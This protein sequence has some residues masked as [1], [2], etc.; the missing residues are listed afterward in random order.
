L[1]RYPVALKQ[2]THYR[3][4]FGRLG[5]KFQ[6]MTFQELQ[7]NPLIRRNLNAMGYRTPR[8][9]QAQAIGP[10]LDGRDVI[11]LAPT[12]TGKTAAFIAPIAHH[13]LESPPAPGN[14]RKAD[15][16]RR[17]R[18]LVLCPTRELAVQV[19]EEA[20][21]IIAGTVLRVAC[22]YGK[23][24]MR[25]QIEQIARGVDLLVAT[26]GRV[27]E[28]LEAGAMNLSHIRHMAVD[29]ADRMLDMGFLPQVEHILE[30][31]PTNRQMALFTATMPGPVEE[32][33]ARFLT[34]PVRI[35]IGRHTTPAE[36]VEQHL[37]EVEQPDKIAMLLHMLRD[38]QLGKGVLIF[39]RTRRRVGWVGTALQRHGVGCGIIHGDRTQAQRLRALEQ[40]SEGRL[41]VIVAS[42]VA[43]RGL[44]I[45]AVTA[46]I[47]YDVPPNAEEYVHRIGRAGHGG[48]R[49]A[50]W[51]LLASND[52]QRWTDIRKQL[53]LRLNA[54]FIDG[55]E[56]TVRPTRSRAKNSK[57]T[58]GRSGEKGQG[59]NRP[60]A[61]GK[62][63]SRSRTHNAPGGGSRKS[64]PIR[65]GEQPGA[66]VRRGPKQDA[67]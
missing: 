42:D 62:S 65:K 53:G 25:D 24:G 11:G 17:L 35:E 18:G 45:P 46:V 39:C 55:F 22:A 19:A 58:S 52:K 4:L 57:P 21:H 20:S 16:A 61:R 28:L 5:Q 1:Q 56:P 23:V 14:K 64:R 50:A 13:L 60:A 67:D 27:R 37:V 8:P 12:G 26:P 15:P 44:H 2:S 47:N 38:A 48:T 7:L 9:I 40:L 51:T 34:S 54:E 3:D 43:A 59:T 29:E 49:G 32:L 33:A 41:R 63:D 66:G 31:V 30:A 36:H 6:P 10:I